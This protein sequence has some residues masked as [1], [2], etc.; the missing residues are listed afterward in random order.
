MLALHA[1]DRSVGIRD[2]EFSLASIERTR[3]AEAGTSWLVQDAMGVSYQRALGCCKLVPAGLCQYKSE[4]DMRILDSQT[5]RWS[6]LLLDIT[7]TACRRVLLDA[8]DGQLIQFGG[9]IG[10]DCDFI[11]QTGDA[12]SVW[13]SSLTASW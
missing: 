8:Y 11:R 1:G 3:R 5:H 9:K 7:P 2:R 10:S 4:D 13:E 6:I 12:E